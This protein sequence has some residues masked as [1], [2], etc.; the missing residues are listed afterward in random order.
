MARYCFRSK[1]NFLRS[2]FVITIVF[3]LKLCAIPSSYIT[4]GFNPVRSAKTT[5]ASYIGEIIS[6]RIFCW[7]SSSPACEKSNSFSK[8]SFNISYDSKNSSVNGIITKTFAF[9][10]VTF[11]VNLTYQAIVVPIVN[12]HSIQVQRPVQVRLI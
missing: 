8:C 12:S 5:S 2:S 7:L 1:G 9:F 11:L 10:I 6:A 4:F 3:L